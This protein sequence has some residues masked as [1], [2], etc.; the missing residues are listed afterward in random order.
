MP[1]I[2]TGLRQHSQQ[3]VADRDSTGTWRILNAWHNSLQGFD[4]DEDDVPDDHEAVTVLTEGA[5]EAVVKHA[6]AEGVLDGI[7][8][9]GVPDA[10]YAEAE[11]E[12]KLL[13]VEIEELSEKNEELGSITNVPS[14]SVLP[15]PAP[16]VKPAPPLSEGA[17]LKKHGMD[18][19]L[20]IIGMDSI[21][22]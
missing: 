9:E 11:E 21:E 10:V 1:E 14:P 7:K 22:G 17:Q 16:V 19:I 15:T 8:F 20:K 4:P 6:T 18:G 5:F 2:G 13:K 3:Y 12:I